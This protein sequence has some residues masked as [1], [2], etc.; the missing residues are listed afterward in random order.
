M[1]QA[2][3]EDVAEFVEERDDFVV[4]QQRRGVAGRFGE[5][6]DDG[7]DGEYVARFLLMAGHQVKSGGVAEFPLA[8]EEIHVEGGELCIGCRIV[9]VV[10]DHIGMPG[11]RV[12]DPTVFEAEDVLGDLEHPVEHL[13]EREVCGHLRRVD[14]ESLPLDVGVQEAMVPRLDLPVAIEGG[15]QVGHLDQ[16]LL[17]ETG[18]DPGVHV[19]DRFG[20]VGHL[21][22]HGV[23]RPGGESEDLGDPVS[24]PHSFFED[25]LV[26]VDR[27]VVKD[28]LELLP[29]IPACGHV[30]EWVVVRIIDADPV[31]VVVG[32][33]GQPRHIVVGHTGE[34]VAIEV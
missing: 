21:Y 29:Q 6:G 23:V 20:A 8:R 3:V 14:T 2:V 9:K 30:H 17:S 28:E 32:A 16:G 11:L 12:V 25:R 5:V 10:G 1:S 19:I 18:D 15:R 4:A 24:D 7:G 33:G 26:L 31:R 22:L 27:L 13:L 34:L